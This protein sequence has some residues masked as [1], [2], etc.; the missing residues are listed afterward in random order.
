MAAPKNKKQSKD[1]VPKGNCGVNQQKLL[2]NVLKVRGRAKLRDQMKAT[3][4]KQPRWAYFTEDDAANEKAGYQNCFSIGIQMRHERNKEG[5]YGEV[6]VHVCSD[7]YSPNQPYVQALHL[8]C[9]DSSTRLRPEDTKHRD[10]VALFG[11]GVPQGLKYYL[12]QGI[13]DILDNPDVRPK[14][15]VGSITVFL[16]ELRTQSNHIRANLDYLDLLHS[17]NQFIDGMHPI[18]HFHRHSVEM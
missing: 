2:L 12:K 7:Q 4:E 13:Y 15:S 17:E 1:N 10:K 11:K 14:Y 16:D 5:V 3:L 9:Y 8:Y 18:L 6:H